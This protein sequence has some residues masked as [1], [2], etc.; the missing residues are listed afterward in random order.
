MKKFKMFSVVA[1]AALIGSGVFYACKKDPVDLNNPTSLSKER[2]SFEGNEFG[3]YEIYTPASEDALY[4]KLAQITECINEPGEVMP[5]IELKEAVYYLEAFF[6]IG[7]CAKQEHPVEFVTKEKTYLM[8][9]IPFERNV[10]NNII[11]NGSTLITNYRAMALGVVGELCG[12]YAINC[13]DFFVHN[14]DFGHNTLTL[15]LTVLYGTKKLGFGSFVYKKLADRMSPHSTTSSFH[16]TVANLPNDGNYVKDTAMYILLNQEI[17]RQAPLGL[18]YINK[19]TNFDLHSSTPYPSDMLSLTVSNAA[20]LEIVNADDNGL[21]SE[22]DYVNR[23]QSCL[24]YIKTDVIPQL[25]L[26]ACYIPWL[27]N[28]VIN[29]KEKGDY[30]KD[31]WHNVGI[32]YT[33]Q[34]CIRIDIVKDA[35]KF[36]GIILERKP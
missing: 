7:V 24:S 4:A 12:E 18:M 28:C 26:P 27:G 14:I 20:V 21:F 19:L 23:S 10:D 3:V 5:N 25:R 9:N 2:K 34:T 22:V 29:S 6:N 1:M 35:T 16:Y 15:G 36:D 30:S 31:I 8:E 32:E 33:A 11:V 17:T 13:G